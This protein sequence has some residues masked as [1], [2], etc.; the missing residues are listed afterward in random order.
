MNWQAIG[1]IGELLGA[2]AVVVSLVYVVREAWEHN[3]NVLAA[4]AR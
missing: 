1:A 3:K 4:L 2:I